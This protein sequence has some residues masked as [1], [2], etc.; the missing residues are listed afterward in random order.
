MFSFSG[1]V[2]KGT[3]KKNGVL[4]LITKEQHEKILE[5]CKNIQHIFPQP[6]QP[7][8]PTWSYD[9]SGSEDTSY[10]AKMLL[11]K[12]RKDAYETL[13]DKGTVEQIFNVRIMPYSFNQVNSGI[14]NGYSLYYQGEFNV[15]K[16]FRAV[17]SGKEA[18]QPKLE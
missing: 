16:R 15:P 7:I 10:Y 1:V 9:A 17:Q 14:C 2:L 13:L 12:A 11:S 4:V 18:K 8:F 5:E 6:A 3:D